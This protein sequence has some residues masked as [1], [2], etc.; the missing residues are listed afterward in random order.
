M[1]YNRLTYNSALYN[2]ARSEFGAIARSIISA[3]T[4]P[5]IQAVVGSDGGVTFVSDFTIDY[6][7]LAF[8]E[9]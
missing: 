9:G 7:L 1:T 3:H 8:T 6:T 2:A 4:G 5:H